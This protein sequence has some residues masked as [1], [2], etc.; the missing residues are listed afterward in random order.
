MSSPP[1]LQ[2]G[3]NEMKRK[4]KKTL[5]TTRHHHDAS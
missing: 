5:K 3:K 4:E 2:K 1:N